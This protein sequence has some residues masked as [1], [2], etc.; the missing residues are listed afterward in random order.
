MVLAREL[1]EKIR[2][3]QIKVESSKRLFSIEE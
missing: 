1:H 3:I 2:N